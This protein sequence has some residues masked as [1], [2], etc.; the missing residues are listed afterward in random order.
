MER[1]LYDLPCII[2][3]TYKRQKKTHRNRIINWFFKKI[4]GYED[5]SYMSEGPD[6]ILFENK[7]IFKDIATMEKLLEGIEE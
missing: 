1:L 3:G 6:V 5:V 4:Y 2:A 7:L